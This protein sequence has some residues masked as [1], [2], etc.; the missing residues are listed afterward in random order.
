[1]ESLVYLRQRRT[2]GTVISFELSECRIE[3]VVE[4]KDDVDLTSTR[5]D[6]SSNYLTM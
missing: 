4:R 1:M 6:M 2:R 5:L 3:F